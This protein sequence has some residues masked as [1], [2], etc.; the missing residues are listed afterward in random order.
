MSTQQR[1]PER[2]YTFHLN[3]NPGAIKKMVIY[4][5][6]L[7]D[8]KT[9]FYVQLAKALMLLSGMEIMSIE[10]PKGEITDGS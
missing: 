1:T 10:T 4:A 9:A 5:D 2:K 6:S 8:A 7:E 3:M